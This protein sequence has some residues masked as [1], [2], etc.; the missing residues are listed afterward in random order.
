M[1][2]DVLFSPAGLASHEVAGRPVFVID[3]L[4]STT[5]IAAALFRGARAV[6]PVATAEEASRLAQNLGSGSAVLVGERHGE[7]IAGFDLDNSPVEVTSERVRG[8]TVVMT[9]TNGIPAFLACQAAADVYGAAACNLSL[10]GARARALL[11]E[12]RDLVI[13]CAG[14]EGK[15]ALDDA[16][17]AGRLAAFALGG[18]RRRKGL[19][20]AAL[21]VLDL[22]RRYGTNWERPLSRS[23]A[24]RHLM[25]TR[26]GD[27][28]QATREDAFPVLPVFRDRRIQ[29][30]ST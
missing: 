14:R 27:F 12:R 10:A 16:Y 6:V 3:I 23:V 7:R 22:A 25:A 5:V 29:S 26:R 2:L 1:K 13:L 28:D 9:T 17:T 19:N 24:G 21:V 30:E 8:K 20:D 15:F 18:T 4:R 11:V